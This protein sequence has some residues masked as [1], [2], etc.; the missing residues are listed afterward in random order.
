MTSGRS[1]VDPGFVHYRSILTLL[2]EEGAAVIN[3]RINEIPLYEPEWHKEILRDRIYTDTLT[4]FCK[5]NGIKPL[6]HLILQGQ[7]E[8]ERLFYSIVKLKACKD[9][10]DKDRTI[11]ECE[12]FEGSDLKVEL[13][14]TTSRVTSSTI[15][16]GLFNGGA[17]AVVAQYFKLEGNRVIFHPLLIGLAGIQYER[18]GVLLNN[19]FYNSSSLHI[20][21]FEEFSRVKDIQQPDSF[22]E[23]RDITERVFKTALGKILSESTPSD[24]GGETSDFVTS[25]LHV[26]GNRVRA[27]FLLK[28]P[29]KFSPMTVKHLGKNGDQIGRLA[30]EPVDV[31]VVQHC[32][33]IPSAIVETLKAFATQPSNPRRYCIIDGRDSLRLL[34]AYGLKE[35]ALCESKKGRNK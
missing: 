7:Y 9:I 27:A 34:E 30:R 4:D 10:Y 6:Q 33:D 25:H 13:P 15:K 22:D 17:F 26:D 5:G 21:N 14:I 1:L 20:E 24:W 18:N 19:N 2:Q 12:P 28:G 31:L 23:M 35:W 11:L 8:Q 32:H 3:Q 16:E 29:S